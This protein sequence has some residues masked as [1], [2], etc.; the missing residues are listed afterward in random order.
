METILRNNNI[1]LKINHFW[2]EINSLLY[3]NRE[4]I[5]KKQENFWQRQSPVLFPTVGALEDNSYIF[6]GQ[7]YH[8]W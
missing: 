4:I 2:A 3:K 1:T 6:E 7:T 5:Y 8:L